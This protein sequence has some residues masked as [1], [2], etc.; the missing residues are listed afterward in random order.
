MTVYICTLTLDIEA[1]TEDEA[2]V[3]FEK[4]M[5]TGQWDSTSIEAEVDESIE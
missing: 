3:E 5:L 4:A 2:R 1:E